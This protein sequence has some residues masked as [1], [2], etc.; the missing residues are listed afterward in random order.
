MSL[1]NYFLVSAGVFV[2]VCGLAHYYSVPASPFAG[3]LLVGETLLGLQV[4]DHRVAR[5]LKQF[6]T[7]AKS[8]QR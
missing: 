4:E 6:F 8:Q 1:K 2:F 7:P 5:A 3:I